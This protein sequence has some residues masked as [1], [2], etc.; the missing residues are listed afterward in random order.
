[1]NY[2]TF[3]CAGGL[4]LDAYNAIVTHGGLE[5]DKDYPY[6]GKVCSL[7]TFQVERKVFVFCDLVRLKS[8]FSATETNWNIETL[9]AAEFDTITVKPM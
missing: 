3:G 4:P 9:Y 1:M 2:T 8:D 5:K 6:T 7:Y